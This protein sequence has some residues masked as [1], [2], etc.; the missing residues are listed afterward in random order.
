MLFSDCQY[1]SAFYKKALTPK[2]STV[3]SIDYDE[4]YKDLKAGTYIKD[5]DA[6]KDLYKNPPSKYVA[7]LFGEVNELPARLFPEIETDSKTVLIYPHQ[8][9]VSETSEFK[10]TVRKSYFKGS[11]YLVLAK[12]ENMV[13]FFESLEELDRGIE[14]GLTINWFSFLKIFPQKVGQI[15][16]KLS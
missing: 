14:V 13:V 3:T 6:Y 12:Y 9:K 5:V 11:H 1:W 8:L 4:L 15:Q 10:V 7:S 2:A 16:A